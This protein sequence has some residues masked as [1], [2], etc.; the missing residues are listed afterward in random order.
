MVLKAF[1]VWENAR[2]WRGRLITVT[3]R[4]YFMLEPIIII[5]ASSEG[6]AQAPRCVG[7]WILHY[8]IT[9]HTC[10]LLMNKFITEKTCLTSCCHLV[11]LWQGI[12]IGMCRLKMCTTWL[13]NPTHS[14]LLM[15]M[16][17]SQ[18]VDKFSHLLKKNK[19][20]KHVVQRHIQYTPL[21]NLRV[22]IASEEKNTLLRLTLEIL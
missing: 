2:N 11:T 12:T 18:F 3:I 1:F 17:G 10:E 16:V 22:S 21:L 5:A 13:L 20:G 9:E 7:M 6:W 19:C 14:Y 8:H 4:L 15:K